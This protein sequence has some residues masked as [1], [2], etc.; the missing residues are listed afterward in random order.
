MSSELIVTTFRHQNR[1]EMILEAIRA[2][3]KRPILCLDSVVVASKDSTGEITLRPAQEP[4]ATGKDSD[5][6]ILLDL[7]G[8]MLCAPAQDA[9]AAIMDEGMDRRFLSEVARSM[10]GESSA[11]FVFAREDSV[12]DADETRS[13]LALFR[14]RIHQTTLPP[15]VEDYL[16]AMSLDAWAKSHTNER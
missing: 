6:K 3:R 13:A 5:T 16:S 14:G 4:A 11:L 7:A 12:H 9:T 10:E 15:E 1:A 8:L 2:M